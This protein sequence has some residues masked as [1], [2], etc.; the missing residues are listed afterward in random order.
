MKYII[1]LITISLIALMM[2][3]TLEGQDLSAANPQ[4]IK[5]MEKGMALWQEGK[6][7]EAVAIFERIAQA[8]K[9]NW[10]PCYYAANVLIVSSFQTKDATVVNEML[11]KAKTIIAKA[12]ERSPNNAEIVTM[13][14]LLYTGYVA[15]DPATFG[16]Q[17]SPKIMGLHSKAIALDEKNPRAATNLIEYEIGGASFFGTEL[18]SFCDR[19]KACIPLFD[20]QKTDYP[21]APSYGKERVTENLKKCGC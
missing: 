3:T 7:T 1:N 18:S 9:D 6:S 11:E 15:M 12:H 2:S 17:Y 13:E 8:E 14:G 20:N 19:L 21:F 16:M 5:G 10:V 4:Y